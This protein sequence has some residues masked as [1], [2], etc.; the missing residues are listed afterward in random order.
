VMG[1]V[2]RSCPCQTQL[3]DQKRM[4]SVGDFA[5]LLSMLCF[6]QGTD[7][8]QVTPLRRTLVSSP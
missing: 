3:V 6:K 2:R 5:W 4:K 1:V 7:T 8:V